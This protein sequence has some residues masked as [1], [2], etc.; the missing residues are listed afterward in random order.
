MDALLGDALGFFCAT[1]LGLAPRLGRDEGGAHER[2]ELLARVLQIVGLIARQLAH[3][4]NL[5]FGIQQPGGFCAKARFELV[6]QRRAVFE[7]EAQIDFARHLVHVLSPRTR[8][9]HRGPTKLG[10]RNDDVSDD[11]SSGQSQRA[12]NSNW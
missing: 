5:A 3:D 7:V 10:F 12:F 9:A 6:T 1:R 8:R 11:Q 2:R 4:S